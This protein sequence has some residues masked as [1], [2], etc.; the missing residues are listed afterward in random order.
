[1]PPVPPA[2]VPPPLEIRNAF[3]ASEFPLPSPLP[4]ED[5]SV[6]ELELFL[7]EDE[8]FFSPGADLWGASDSADVDC[9]AVGSVAGG[10]VFSAGAFGEE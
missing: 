3:L 1:M 6:E 8:G 10:L 4:E 5:F 7:A 9:V 2:P